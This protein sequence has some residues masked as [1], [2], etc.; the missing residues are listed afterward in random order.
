MPDM[1]L[2]FDVD[3]STDA[4][5]TKRELREGLERVDKVTAVTTPAA[6]PRFTG[7]EILAAIEVGVQ[8][9]QRSGEIV[10][11][12]RQAADDLKAIV[13]NLKPM[14]AKIASV[15]ASLKAK[16]RV[17]VGLATKPI[18]ELTDEDYQKIAAKLAPLL[19]A[20]SNMT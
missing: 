11:T 17:P 14:F 4:D 3:P 8:I 16:V 10:R 19:Q 15:A 6:V 12:A 2:Y 13:D 9:A 1:T 5:K 7:L 18:S 20:K